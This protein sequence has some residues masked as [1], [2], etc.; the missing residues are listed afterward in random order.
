M[1][2]TGFT[3]LRNCQHFQLKK[4]IVLGASQ[5]L[6]SLQE[7]QPGALK[8]GASKPQLLLHWCL[9]MCVKGFAAGAFCRL[10]RAAP[11]SFG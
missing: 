9:Q 3:Y 7:G 4:E 10:S 2:T 11:C 1:R 5:R 6:W 8:S